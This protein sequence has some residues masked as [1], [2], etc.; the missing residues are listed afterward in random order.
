MKRFATSRIVGALAIL[1]VIFFVATTAF[2]AD[3]E[4][5]QEYSLGAYLDLIDDGQVE[6]AVIL[7][8]T[9]EI[10]GILTNGTEYELTFPREFADELTIALTEASPSVDVTTNLGSSNF[11]REFALRMAP[12]LI[13]VGLIVFV[14]TKMSGGM[15]SMGKAKARQF[16]KDSPQITFDAVSY[17]HLT[18]PTT[19][20]V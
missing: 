10:A 7:D 11:W 17:T 6:S 20:Y 4:Q 15:F 16:T 12:M 3:S 18:L 14:L 8:R 5:R 19:P 9:Q 13:L 1:L 2:G